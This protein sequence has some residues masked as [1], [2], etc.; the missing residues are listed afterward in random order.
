MSRRMKHTYPQA[1]D[2]VRKGQVDVR[3]IVT[4]HFRLDQAGEAFRL[5][6]SYADNVLKTVIQVG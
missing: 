1:I 6:D 5:A 2:L 3:S 4:H